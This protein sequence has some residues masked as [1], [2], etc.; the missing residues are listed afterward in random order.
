MGTKGQRKCH[1]CKVFSYLTLV[2]QVVSVTAASLSAALPANV[3][4]Q[5]WCRKNPTYF[6]A[7]IHVNRVREWCSKHPGYWKKK[8]VSFVL[9]HTDALQDSLELQVSVL[10]GVRSFNDVTITKIFLEILIRH[11]GTI[12]TK[13]KA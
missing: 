7:S 13:S 1:N 6:R 3:S 12:T 10:Q 2:E 11:Y 4:Q 8:P 9:P 5:R